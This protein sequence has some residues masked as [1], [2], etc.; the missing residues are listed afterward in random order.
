[1][2]SSWIISTI[3]AQETVDATSPAAVLAKLEREEADYVQQLA[4]WCVGNATTFASFKATYEQWL[5]MFFSEDGA[6]VGSMAIM[7]NGKFGA[8]IDTGIGN[9]KDAPQ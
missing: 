2:F 8:A 4:G 5:N 9:N 6:D 3:R 7:K 1:M